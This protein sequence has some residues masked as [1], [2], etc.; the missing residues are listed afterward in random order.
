[1]PQFI[2]DKSILQG[3]SDYGEEYFSLA[4]SERKQVSLLFPNIRGFRESS[5][6][7]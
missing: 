2:V 7:Q 4:E 1:M 5:Q 3:M 6:L